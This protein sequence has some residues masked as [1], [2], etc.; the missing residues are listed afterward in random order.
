MINKGLV[1]ALLIAVFGLIGFVIWQN[2]QIEQ[3][4]KVANQNSQVTPVSQTKPSQEDMSAP[5]SG[6]IDDSS[7]E[8]FIIPELRIRFKKITGITPRYVYNETNQSV[9]FSTN[10]FNSFVLDNQKYLHCVTYFYPSVNVDLTPSKWRDISGFEARKLAD[11]RYLMIHWSPVG[12]VA[13]EETKSDQDFIEN[14]ARLFEQFFDT[15]HSY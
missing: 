5:D 2:Y 11:G 15:V 13:L 3:S 1:I 8:Y 9:S 4:S 6:F 14:Q 12:C 7:D 10:E